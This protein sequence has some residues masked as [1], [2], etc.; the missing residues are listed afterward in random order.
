MSIPQKIV[1]RL[2]ARGITYQVVEEESISP[3]H[4][5][6]SGDQIPRGQ[7]VQQVVLEDSLGR[8]QVLVP[9]D[10]LLDL[11][12]LCEDK[13]RNLTAIS[14]DTSRQMA[15]SLGMET[16]PAI[17]LNDN[18]PLIIDRALLKPTTLYL[19]VSQSG[20]YLTLP[21]AEFAKLVANAQSGDFSVPLTRLSQD[22]NDRAAV[23]QAVQNFTNLRIRQRL[24]QTLE[25][26][27]L[28]DTAE[29][30]IKLRIDP[31]ASV[32]ELVAIVEKDPSLAA[33]VVSWASS[34][35]YAAPGAIRSVHDAVVRVLGF[36]LVINL[37][38]GLALGKSIELPKDGP[39]GVQPFW[40]QAVFTASLMEGLV[41]AMPSDYRPSIGLAY[42]CGLLSNYGYLVLA[43]IFPPYFSVIN[44]CIEANPHI[45]G[46]YVEQHLLS[47][48]RE[49]IS[50]QLMDCWSMPDEI[51]VGLRWQHH[52]G[53]NGNMAVYARLLHLANQ[54]LR[55]VELVPGPRHALDDTLFDELHLS[56]EDVAS[57]LNHMVAQKDE[58]I[59]IA[60]GLG[61][62]GHANG[63][64]KSNGKR[65]GK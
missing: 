29:R 34:P 15:S 37:A 11:Q 1:D 5:L 3:L 21:Q 41:K 4:P 46:F 38:L 12:K 18:L 26:P 44:R 28:P 36:D 40:Q 48:T 9:A 56:R 55:S 39:N 33:Q 27:P 32:K 64:G 45:E 6:L 63:N 35:Y 53:F 50:S 7:I 43:H 60:R 42:L 59:K 58:L 16:L 25:M 51:V 22:P 65:N 20:Q 17:P 30:I 10:R 14:R 31:N 57:V 61:G 8:V 54:L 49:T 62:N 47:V 19:E 24:E 13:G 2:N 23:H 52:P